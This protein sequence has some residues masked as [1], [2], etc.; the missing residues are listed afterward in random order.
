[1]GQPVLLA[2]DEE[3]VLQECR[4]QTPAA[5]DKQCSLMGRDETKRS[6]GLNMRKVPGCEPP[7]S[8]EKCLRLQSAGKDGP[9]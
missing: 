5:G 8:G 2:A 7:K 3:E 9:G 4:A 1:M 6:S